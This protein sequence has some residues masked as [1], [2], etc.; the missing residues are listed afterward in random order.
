MVT[1]SMSFR[2]GGWEGRKGRA[3]EILLNSDWEIPW[4]GKPKSGL[5]LHLFIDRGGVLLLSSKPW[6][7]WVCGRV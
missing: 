6:N 1:D 4:K 3:G 5:L 7:W 2:R